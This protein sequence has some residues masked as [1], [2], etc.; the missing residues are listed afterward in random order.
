MSSLCHASS[1]FENARAI[2]SGD[3][4]SSSSTSV[5]PP[6]VAA[7]SAAPSTSM[8]APATSAPWRASTAAIAAPIPPLVPEPVTSAFCPRRSAI[9]VAALSELRVGAVGVPPDRILAVVS[10]PRRPLDRPLVDLDPESGSGRSSE[11]ALDDVEDGAIDEVVEE[12]VAEVGDGLLLDQDVRRREVDLQRRGQRNRP[13]GTVWRDDDVV[14]LRQSRDSPSLG[15]PAGLRDVRLRDREPRLEHLTEVPA[16][17]EP[18]TR[19]DRKRGRLRELA[20]HVQLLRQQRLLHEEKLV[21]LELRQQPARGRLRPVAVDVERD[22]PLRPDRIAERSY[23]RHDLVRR[24]RR[25]DGERFRRRELE[26]TESLLDPALRLVDQLL[27]GELAEVVPGDPGVCPHAIANGAAEELVDGDAVELAGNVPQCFVDRGE[28]AGEDR[29]VAVEPRLAHDLPVSLDRQGVPSDEVV[30]EIRHRRLDR[31]R[32]HLDPALAPAGDPLVR[33][34]A[35]EQPLRRDEESVHRRDLQAGPGAGAELGGTFDR[36]A[37]CIPA[38]A[39][40]AVPMGGRWR[41]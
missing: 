10:D 33:P 5:L 19:R 13:E 7:T 4:T 2:D 32:A 29:P 23:S 21:P 6:I 40:L 30:G 18:L 28:G 37:H 14:H 16:V 41:G 34:D 9:I 3:A 38:S 35:D 12:V 27:L 36:A 15:D 8:S 31:T 25:I 17:V 24:L 26:C 1:S 22:V 39:R 11:I 20:E